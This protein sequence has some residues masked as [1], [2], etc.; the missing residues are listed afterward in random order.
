MLVSEILAR[1]GNK[2]FKIL[3]TKAMMDAVQGMA[4]FKVGAVLVVDANDVTQ[5]IFTERDVT[6]CLAAHGAGVLE[7]P[8]GEHMTRNPLVC[9]ATDSVASV[10][11][12]MSTHHFRHMPVF[13]NGKMIGI[14]SIRDLVSNSLERAE[15]E[16]EA[17]R[18][19]VTA[20]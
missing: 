3:P 17:M 18:A 8:V 5:G 12:Q 4:S 10:M 13:D 1:K 16:A 6:R 14:V 15:F 11:S 7:A 9:K 20:S 19:Y 2:V